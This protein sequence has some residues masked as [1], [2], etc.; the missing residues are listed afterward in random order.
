MVNRQLSCPLLSTGVVPSSVK[1]A[2][3]LPLLK[4]PGLDPD[5]LKHYLPIPNIRFIGKV[6]EN[7][8]VR[9]VID[10]LHTH[11]LLDQLQSACRPGHGTETA[12]LNV[13]SDINLALDRAHGA[14]LVLLDLSTAFDTI[15]HTILLDRLESHCGITGC[16][17][18]WIKSYL[19]GR[20]SVSIHREHSL[21]T[22]ENS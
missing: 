12:L 13:K 9:Q 5:E 20:N 22:W 1:E 16:A 2:V 14:I 3:I 10:Y 15:D 6:M 21:W 11:N 18:E 8:V 7:V 17:K 19:T 4:K